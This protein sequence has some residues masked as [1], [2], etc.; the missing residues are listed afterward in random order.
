MGENF[1]DIYRQIGHPIAFSGIN[2]SSRITTNA[3]EELSHIDSYTRHRFAAKPRHRNPIYV[4]GKREL[5]QADLADVRHLAK[6]NQG[7]AYLLIVIDTFSRKIWVRPLKTKHTALVV[8]NMKNILDEM[9]THVKRLLTDRGGEFTSTQFRAL[10]RDY[11]INYQLSNSEIKAPHVERVIGTLKHLMHQYL[12]ENETYTYIDHIGAIVDTYNGRQHTAHKLSPND[13]DM[14]ANRTRVLQELTKRFYDKAL[15]TKVKTHPK[16]KIGDIV[17]LRIYPDKFTRGFH[18][19][20]TG[21]M[22]KISKIYEN[23]PHVQYGVSTYDLKEE[24]D[25]RFYP[26]ELQIVHPDGVFKVEKVLS[27]KL[28]NKVPHILVKWL[29]FNDTYNEWIPESNVDLTYVN[30]NND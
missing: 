23:L 7:V 18:E 25:G 29:H 1:R 8:R 16:L 17:R 10:L 13:A 28:I 22:F 2:Q 30:N 14:D 24:I 27:K 21:E 12:T 11:N 26:A 19:T 15:F 6:Y 3:Q 5:I 9:N 20:F 4:Y